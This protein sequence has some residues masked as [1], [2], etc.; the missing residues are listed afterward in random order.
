MIKIS[1]TT[2]DVEIPWPNGSGSDV[3]RVYVA[4]PADLDGPIRFGETEAQAVVAL[5]N[6]RSGK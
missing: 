5:L 4:K 3:M 2:M 6:V 1:V